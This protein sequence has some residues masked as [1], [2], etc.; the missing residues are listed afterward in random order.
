M[1][2]SSD[3][4]VEPAGAAQCYPA[5]R[6]LAVA[7]VLPLASACTR[8]DLSAVNIATTVT[9]TNLPL[10]EP[11]WQPEGSFVLDEAALQPI[12]DAM[13]SFAPGATIAINATDNPT[14]TGCSNGAGTACLRLS[15]SGDGDAIPNLIK[16]EKVS[17]GL[18]TLVGIPLDASLATYLALL[19]S[20]PPGAPVMIPVTLDPSAIEIK[21]RGGQ[22]GVWFPVLIEPPADQFR[23]RFYCDCDD[24][25]A[26]EV[27]DSD[28][29]NIPAEL[30]P[31]TMASVSGVNLA[32]GLQ[33]SDWCGATEAVIA[34][35]T[36]ATTPPDLGDVILEILGELF[37]DGGVCD[38]AA[39]IKV[40]RVRL[41]LGFIPELPATASGDWTTSFGNGKDFHVPSMFGLRPVVRSEQSLLAISEDS[42]NNDEGNWED[43]L[44]RVMGAPAEQDLELTA[45]AVDCGFAVSV[46][47]DDIDG[48]QKM[49]DALANGISGALTGGLQTAL[50]AEVDNRRIFTFDDPSFPPEPVPCG[51]SPVQPPPICTTQLQDLVAATFTYQLWDWFYGAFGPYPTVNAGGGTVSATITGITTEP[52]PATCAGPLAFLDPECLTWIGT[53]PNWIRFDWDAD[54]DNDGVNDVWD[55]CIVVGNP[56]QV[57]T[58]GDEKG[59][60]CDICPKD[61]L[62]DQDHDGKC[63]SDDNCMLV[64]N[65][66]Q[67]NCNLVSEQVHTP[68]DLRGDACDPVPCPDVQV[69][70]QVTITFSTG[71]ICVAGYCFTNT[72][73]YVE[74]N[75]F[76]VLPLA[77]HFADAQGEPMLA[78]LSADTA[79][80]WCQPNP[81][82]SIKCFEDADIQD[83]LVDQAGCAPIFGQPAPCANVEIEST[84]FHRMSFS[85]F[86]NGSDPNGVEQTMA[87]ERAAEDPGPG[88]LDNDDWTWDYEADVQRWIDTGL[89]PGL[90][91]DPADA[92]WKLVGT[93]WLHARTFVGNTNL[94]LGTGYHG[95]ELANHHELKLAAKKTWSSK[96]SSGGLIRY[97]YFFWQDCPWCDQVAFDPGIFERHDAERYETSIILRAGTDWGAL[98][99]KGHLEIVTSRLGPALLSR[100]ADP[101]LVWTNAVEPFMTQGAV[102]NFPL[103]LALSADG[104]DIVDAIATNG[105]SLL[106]DLDQNRLRDPTLGSPHVTGFL[107]VLTRMRRGVFVVGGDRTST[108]DPS[109]EIWWSAADRLTDNAWDLVDTAPYHVEHAVAATYSFATDRL[110]VLDVT[111]AGLARLTA[112]DP[113][114]SRASLLGTWTWTGAW[115]AQWLV[116]DRDGALLLASSS[117]AKKRYRIARIDLGDEGTVV[118]VRTGHKALAL[119]P[120]V[121]AA[122]YTLVHLHGG[123]KLKVKRVDR[124]EAGHRHDD[125]DKG[126]KGKDCDDGDAESGLAALGGQL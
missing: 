88:H 7:L 54:R 113:A 65:S 50:Q 34:A 64:E 90:G 60:V 12:R 121:D 125:E 47:V 91:S 71:N 101:S 70:K 99:R 105:A 55:N 81:F 74:S 82:A 11:I 123:D 67:L 56:Q 6:L 29:L 104:S 31:A 109:G 124:L 62:D 87:Y 2:T 76:T 8:A 48:S 68:D 57:D 61:P 72:A 111:S 20:G 42:E 108:G 36:N 118:T 17:Y 69:E 39:A 79:A 19:D 14:Q 4:A 30:L 10:A 122:G 32:D 28:T 58:D 43:L 26:D 110:Y 80:R 66:A 46:G 116:V 126:K 94:S 45:N 23:K 9:G 41:F 13:A 5:A 63:D 97:P 27:A 115:D 75:K 40:N 38:L 120:V 33:C 15:W 96:S 78:T 24:D 18:Q 95:P 73:G 77:S 1:E 25:D 92:E 49:T 106:A 37:I 107:P 3:E 89:M 93:R 119:P 22:V 112:I 44:D 35:A 100:L 117:T 103:A 83:E 21:G 53:G 51:L 102:K 16:D 59:D 52:A 84:R 85:T 98:D 114:T 86:G